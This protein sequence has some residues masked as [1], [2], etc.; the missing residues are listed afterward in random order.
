MDSILKKV[1]YP[2]DLKRLSRDQLKYLAAEIRDLIIN[3]VSSN[4]GHLASSLGT[5][6]IAIALHYS[7]DTP[8]DKIIWDVGHQAYAHMILTGRGRDFPTLRTT[9]GLPGFLKPHLSEYDV[10]GAGHASTSIAAALGIARARD[11][12]G[13]D[14]NVVSIIGDGSMTCGLVYEALDVAGTLGT[15]FMII[16]NDNEMSISRNVGAVS[17]MF[18]RIITDDWYNHTKGR[19]EDLVNRFRLGE[20]RIGE[21]M[22]RFSHRVEESIKGLIVPGL[23]FEELGFR[24]I[25]PING[26]DLDT[27]IPAIQKTAAFKGPRI[28]HVVTKKGKGYRFAE[29][30]PEQFHS[31]PPFH[32]ETGKKKKS[33]GLSFTSAFG[34]AIVELAEKD[35]RVI[36][37]TA[38]MP[39]GTGLTQFA[40]RFPDRFYDF[41]IAEG[42]AV[43]TA[44]GMAMEGF[45]PVVAI[46]ST[47]LQRSFDMIIHDVALQGL[48]VIFALDR[49]GIVGQD[50]PTHHGTFD[51]SYLRMIPE[52]II[53]A[54]RS[55]QELRRCL[56]T[57]LV[58]NKGPVA[59]RYPRGGSDIKDLDLTSIPE[60]FAV[61]SGQWLRRGRDAAII[62]VGT[63]SNHALAAAEI[64]EKHGISISVA[65][66]RF[67]KPLD[68][69]L[70]L[71]AIRHPLCFTVED[72]VI[73]GGFGSGVNE[74]LVER[75]TGAFCRLL[76]LPDNFVE[77]GSPDDLYDRYG[78]SPVKIAETIRKA[79]ESGNGTCPDAPVLHG[80]MDSSE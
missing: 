10:F 6:E 43:I 5:I 44:A 35:E 53:M 69:E 58:W 9:G 11:L 67:V 39:S 59:I 50:G 74:W 62:G 16:L 20:R 1:Q 79:V 73:A 76:G 60:P 52:M 31:A 19:L 15:S 45:R 47:F 37:I 72:N 12:K 41:G 66:T 13:E 22:V 46:Y 29:E 30:N 51:L 48:P 34:K 21:Q 42:A 71:E 56:A 23:F 78:L 2:R 18:N 24:Y 28:L 68:E 8:K 49:A 80:A 65:D 61:P 63:M 54:P 40:E 25:G 32:I 14:F 4:G 64:L 36:A 3:T 77:H 70:I 26:N 33:S 38:A 55:E 7:L 57:A 27:L 17:Q 75:E